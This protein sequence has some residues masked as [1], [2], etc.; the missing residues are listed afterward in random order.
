M[1]LLT[2]RRMQ[3]YR[4]EGLVVSFARLDSK[5]CV[6]YFQG[7]NKA[8][9]CDAGFVRLGRCSDTSLGATEAEYAPSI[10]HAKPFAGFHVSHVTF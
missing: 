4:G 1:A 9:Y 7:E 5:S 2:A 6:T 10:S 3:E 8:D